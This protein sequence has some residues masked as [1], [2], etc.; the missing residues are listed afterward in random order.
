MCQ[1]YKSYLLRYKMRSLLNEGLQ[2][3]MKWTKMLKQIKLIYSVLLIY[4]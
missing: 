4:G 1:F 3:I 2:I